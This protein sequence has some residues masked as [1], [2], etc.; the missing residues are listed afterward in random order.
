MRE[1]D[2][3]RAALLESL[4]TGK[5]G[6]DRVFRP[7]LD[8]NPGFHGE[9]LMYAQPAGLTWT[10]TSID[11]PYGGAPPD[12]SIR[13]RW[14]ELVRTREIFARDNGN[15]IRI[16]D[17]PEPHRHMGPGGVGGGHRLAQGPQ[18]REVAGRVSD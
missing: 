12:H 6:E 17:K 16:I 13:G 10:E 8:M 15:S 14:R 1:S 5:G 3:G 4:A 18:L 11:D 9:L 2:G 7:K